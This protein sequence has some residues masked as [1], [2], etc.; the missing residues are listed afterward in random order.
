M[1]GTMP[2]P[3]MHILTIAS[4]IVSIHCIPFIATTVA[5]AMKIDT[6]S[7]TIIQSWITLTT[8]ISHTRAFIN[9]YTNTY[10]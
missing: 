3:L 6:V 2:L 7:Y 1:A 4:H 9:I 10:I 8:T 5:G